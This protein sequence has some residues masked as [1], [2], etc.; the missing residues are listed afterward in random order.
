ML[1]QMI[2]PSTMRSAGFLGRMTKN[3][4]QARS[5]ATV[6]GNTQRAIPTPSMRRAT[7]VSNEPATFTIKVRRVV[8]HVLAR[9]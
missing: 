3:R 4:V 8:P 1:S 2:K 5:L 9:H 7:A 6:E